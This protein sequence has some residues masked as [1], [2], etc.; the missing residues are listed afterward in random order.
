MNCVTSLG[1]AFSASIFGAGKVL[2]GMFEFVPTRE[3][4]QPLVGIEGAASVK[5]L[6]SLHWAGIVELRKGVRGGIRLAGATTGVTAG[7]VIDTEKFPASF[8]PP[9][10]SWMGRLMATTH[11]WR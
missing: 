9:S 5:I 2:R 4:T 11:S 3:V 7:G 10:P 8:R 1:S 6:E